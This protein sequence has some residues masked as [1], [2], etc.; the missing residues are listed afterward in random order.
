MAASQYFGALGQAPRGFS[1]S[2]LAVLVL[3]PKLCGESSWSL[4]AAETYR[5]L[6]QGARGLGRWGRPAS[7][8]EGPRTEKRRETPFP[9]PQRALLPLDTTLVVLPGTK[10]VGGDTPYISGMTSP[11]PRPDRPVKGHLRRTWGWGEKVAAGPRSEGKVRHGAQMMKGRHRYL[12]S[13]LSGL[14]RT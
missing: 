4:V 12:G 7:H 3:P 6:S 14:E 8:P 9:A 11:P 1:G 5:L 10:V 2:R 13:R